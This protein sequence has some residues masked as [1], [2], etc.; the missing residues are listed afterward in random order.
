LC[1]DRLVCGTDLCRVQIGVGDRFVWEADF[2]GE[3]FLCAR[4]FSV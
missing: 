1:A 2:E 4:R 3:T